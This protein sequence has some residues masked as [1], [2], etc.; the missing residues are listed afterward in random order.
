MFYDFVHKYAG[1]ASYRV[2]DD[3]LVLFI[4]GGREYVCSRTETPTEFIG[5]AMRAPGYTFAMWIKYACYDGTNDLV[6]GI[7]DKN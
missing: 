3:H 1:N 2:I 7:Y 4:H 6:L 5:N